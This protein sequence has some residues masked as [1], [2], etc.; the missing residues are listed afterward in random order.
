MNAEEKKVKEQEQKQNMKPENGKI[1]T[2]EQMEK[3]TGGYIP[4]N[5]TEKTK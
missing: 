5:L 4:P 2:N 3:V 1:L